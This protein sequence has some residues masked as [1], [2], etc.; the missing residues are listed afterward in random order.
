M[1]DENNRNTLADLT[2]L[3]FEAKR[4]V[5]DMDLIPQDD[6]RDV[7]TYT[8]QSLSSEDADHIAYDQNEAAP[9]DAKPEE[10]MNP[11]HS[12]IDAWEATGADPDQRT[13]ADERLSLS[14]DA[15]EADEVRLDRTADETVIRDVADDETD[16]EW[17][18]IEGE[19]PTR[20]GDEVIAEYTGDAKQR[21]AADAAFSGSGT[22][23]LNQDIFMNY[24]SGEEEYTPLEDVP[25]ADAIAANSP[26]DP[27]APPTEQM[28]GTD[29]LN[30][31]NGE[32]D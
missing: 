25:D 27:A 3:E 32:D 11:D 16:R 14:S 6:L 28:H 4:K 26:V 9:A 31:S 8:E 1:R 12:A 15:G 30:G 21:V 19:P 17:R 7:N 13:I 5:E 29:L 18:A 23:F 22:A 24:P 2:Y 20:P 10:R